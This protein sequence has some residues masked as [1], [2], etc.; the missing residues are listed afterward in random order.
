MLY[1]IEFAVT[2]IVESKLGGGGRINVDR[3]LAEP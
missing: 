1:E 3:S 2:I